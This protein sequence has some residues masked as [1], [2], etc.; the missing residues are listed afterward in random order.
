MGSFPGSGST[1]KHGTRT[2]TDGI[3]FSDIRDE[4][5]RLLY[6]SLANSTLESYSL[7]LQRFDSFRLQYSLIK[8]WPPNVEHIVQF[9]AMLSLSGLSHAT[10]RLYVAGIGFHCKVQ[11]HEDVTKHFLVAKVLEG[12]KR[13]NACLHDRRLPVTVSMLVKVVSKLPAICSSSYESKLFAAA[14]C[15]AFFGFFRVGELAVSRQSYIHRVISINDIT[16]DRSEKILEIKVKY[17]K[18]DQVGRGEFLHLLSQG[19]SICPVSNVKAYL[20][21][22]PKALGPF[23]IHFDGKPLTRYQF[24]AVLKKSLVVLGMNFTL[25]KSHSFRIGAATA[26]AE[27]G[28]SE[29]AIK[30]AGRWKSSAYKSYV[31]STVN[32][33]PKLVQ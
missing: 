15:L 9:I 25:F 2:V 8:N 3:S 6:A 4:A 18:T 19:G 17:S 16:L 29:D 7:G 11:G 1:S 21:I 31:R 12:L 30:L 28:L 22:R 13:S 26:A 33:L 24:S 14:Y 32:V 10:A 20:E 5:S 23:L 27:L